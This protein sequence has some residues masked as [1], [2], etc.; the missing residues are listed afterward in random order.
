LTWREEG[1]EDIPEEIKKL[2]GERRRKMR[3]LSLIEWLIVAAIII[4]LIVIML[5]YWGRLFG[6]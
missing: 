6:W 2:A 4:I 3:Q 5:P 1:R